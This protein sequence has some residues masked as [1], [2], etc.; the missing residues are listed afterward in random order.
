MPDGKFQENKD[1]TAGNSQNNGKMTLQKY[2]ANPVP[3]LHD[4]YTMIDFYGINKRIQ[5]LGGNPPQ[6][7]I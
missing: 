6:D 3:R 1:N 7:K 5:E 4:M 2:F